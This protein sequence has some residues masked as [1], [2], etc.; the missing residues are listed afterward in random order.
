MPDPLT[1][2]MLLFLYV[3]ADFSLIGLTEYIAVAVMPLRMLPPFCIRVWDYPN[4]QNGHGPEEAGFGRLS[5][6]WPHF[7]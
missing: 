3:G 1:S 2:A 7:L 5:E 6:V 4:K